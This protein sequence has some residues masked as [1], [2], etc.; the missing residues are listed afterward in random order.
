MINDAAGA[1]IRAAACNRL[2][3][4]VQDFMRGFVDPGC[5]ADR[6]RLSAEG[7][8]RAAQRQPC[9]REPHNANSSICVKALAEYSP[10]HR[11]TPQLERRNTTFV[12]LLKCKQA[13]EVNSFT[14]DSKAL[15]HVGII[16]TC[17]SSWLLP[18]R[19]RLNNGTSLRLGLVFA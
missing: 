5:I 18:S 7:G 16:Y 11:S 12:L 19:R 3:E 2:V 17:C 8:W 6:A 9:N 15:I 10:N 13:Y 14:D 4:V 1:E